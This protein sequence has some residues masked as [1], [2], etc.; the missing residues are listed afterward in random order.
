M[1][2]L[3]DLAVPKLLGGISEVLGGSAPASPAPPPPSTPATPPPAPPNPGMPRPS[4]DPLDLLTPEQR[5]QLTYIGV[6][7]TT[8]PLSDINRALTGL[9]E[10]ALASTP[11]QPPAQGQQPAPTPAGPVDGLDGAAAEAAVRVDNALQ[12]NHSAVNDADA[13]L[14]EAILRASASDQQGKARLQAL[15][16]SI[17]DEVKNLGP[18]LDAPAGQQQ[19]ADF[20]QGKTAEIL[21]V[22]KTAGL[23]AKSHG[24]V[25]DALAARY[26]AVGDQHGGGA[27]ERA[28]PGPPAPTSTAAVGSPPAPAGSAPA[29]VAELPNDPLL[30]GL[31]SDPFLAGLGSLAGPTLGALGGLPGMMG[32]MMPPFGGGM[33]GG[34][35]PLGDLG[36]SIGGA[37]RD[38]L[39]GSENT[40]KPDDLKDRPSAKTDPPQGHDTGKPE[41]LKDQQGDQRSRPSAGPASAPAAPAADAAPAPPPDTSVRLPDGTSVSADSPALAKAGR[42]VLAGA[43][44]D[45]AYQQAGITLSAPGTPVSSP[46]SPSQ[47]V[48][49]DVGQFTDHRVMALGAGKVWVNGQV[50]PLDQLDTGPNFLGWEHPAGLSTAAAASGR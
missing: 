17:L 19:L 40:D 24:A 50:S 20:L 14:T 32:S 4:G 10:R 3:G 39:H 8:A 1:T 43:N 2:W 41:P 47:L 31:A 6:D 38:A 29:G 18:T 15:Q 27:G 16:Q 48:F 12:R 45:D 23:D 46:V 35:V 7:P 13:Q 26:Q 21:D 33:G 22:L 34:G 25:M 37:I 5:A 36:S 9:G 30:N 44:I 11:Q 28:A 42:A 49:G